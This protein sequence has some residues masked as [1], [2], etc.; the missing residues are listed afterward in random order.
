MSPN[1]PKGPVLGPLVV[2]GVC[3]AQSNLHYLEKIGV[4][5]SKLL[6]PEKRANLSK[7]IKNACVCYDSLVI[8]AQE[9]DKRFDNDINLNGLEMNK[10]AE[11]INELKPDI[12]YMDAADTNAEKFK[13]LIGKKLDYKPLKLISEHKADENYP[14]VSA[15]SIIAKHKR[16]MIIT[17]LR[18]KYLNMGYSDLGSGYP[19]DELT[20]NF[21]KEWIRIEKRAPTFA[22]KTWQ[23]TKKILD[24]ELYN[25]KITQ[26]FNE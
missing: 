24:L 6:S 4:K 8:S 26:Y 14:I 11:I 22:R 10:F 1:C 18:E 7:L 17:S 21:L 16:D 12:V 9:I 5:D 20:I 15:A 19:S 3:F 13:N 25:R 2:C 23:T